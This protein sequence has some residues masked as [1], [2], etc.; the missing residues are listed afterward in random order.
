MVFAPAP[1]PAADAN[2]LKEVAMVSLPWPPPVRGQLSSSKS[3]GEPINCRFM[4]IQCS[5]NL[6][7]RLSLCEQLG[8][9]LD[10]LRIQLARP[11][12]THASLLGRFPSRTGP[13]T[14]EITLEFRDTSKDRHNHFGVSVVLER[15]IALRCISSLVSSL[16][17]QFQAIRAISPLF[18]SR[19]CASLSGPNSENI[20]VLH[21]RPVGTRRNHGG[22]NAVRSGK[23][24]RVEVAT[25]S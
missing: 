7:D 17:R 5:S 21:R 8:G 3:G 15:K 10:L 24:S 18:V 4:D 11:S 16:R 1:F 22:E 23:L 2:N 25:P 13:L 9:D 20:G 12:A 6:F 14:N 19:N